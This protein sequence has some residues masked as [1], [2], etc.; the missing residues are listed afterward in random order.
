MT[1]LCRK[2]KRAHYRKHGKAWPT[3]PQPT[4][5]HSDGGYSTLRPTKG[6][7][8]ISAARLRAQRRMASILS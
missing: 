5:V 8:H 7:T 4:A 2:L 3:R 1:S 6:W